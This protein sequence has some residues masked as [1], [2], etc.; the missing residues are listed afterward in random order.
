MRFIKLSIDGYGR[1]TDREIELA[2]GLQVVAGPNEQGKS[3]LRYFIADMLY[4][5]KRSAA[6]RLYE[7]SNELRAPWGNHR[8]YGGRLTYELD[9][10][11]VFEVQRRFDRNKE[12]THIFDRT[13]ACDITDQFPVA[14][15]RESTFAEAH[16][17]I[18][19][20]V[21]VGTATISHVSLADLGDQEALTRIRE[22]LLSLTDSAGE[23]NSAEDAIKML[24]E[25]VT[26]IGQPN[27]RTKPLPQARARLTDLQME[28][29]QVHEARRAIVEIEDERLGVLDEIDELRTRRAALESELAAREHFDQAQLLERAQGLEKRIDAVTKECFALRVLRDFPLARVPEVQ[30][31]VTLA[32]TARRQINRTKSELGVFEKQMDEQVGRLEREGQPIM[33]EC[34]PEW[35][36]ALADAD[37]RIQRSLGRLGELE[38]AR[39]E[40]EIRFMG[41][42]QEL[43]RLPDY[44]RL[45]SDPV[46]WLTQLAAN[47]DTVRRARDEERSTLAHL[48]DTAEQRRQSIAEASALF[49]GQEEVAERIHAYETERS[50]RDRSL[51][52]LAEEAASESAHAE[53]LAARLP[54]FTIFAA[55]SFVGTIVLLVIALA[56]G[57]RGLFL[58]TGLVAAMF[59]FVSGS[60]IVTRR[61]ASRAADNSQLL[62]EEREALQR[63]QP[64]QPIDVGGLLERSGCETTRELEAL[65]DRYAEAT[66][67]LIALDTRI[68]EQQTRVDDAAQQVDEMFA[69]LRTTFDGMGQTLADEDGVQTT[70]MRSIARYQEFRDSKRRGMEN[71][72]ALRRYETECAELNAALEAIRAEELERSLEVRA[73]LRDNH[74]ED[75]SN[76]DGALQALRAYRIRSAQHRQKQGMVD[77]SAG[78][79]KVLRRRIESEETDLASHEVALGTLLEGAGCETVEEFREKSEQAERYQVRWKERAALEDQLKALLGDKDV[80]SLRLSVR[81]TGGSRGQSDGRAVEELRGALQEVLDSLETKRTI[82]HDLHLK[83]AECSAGMRSMNEVDE[84]RESVE[85]RIREL[86]LELQ[87]TSYAISVIEE[88]TRERHTR[89]APKLADLASGYL[90]EIT[91]GV[92]DELLVDRDLQISIRIPQTKAMNADPERQLSKG[93]VDQIYLALRLAMVR[94]MSDQSET[95][96]MVLDDPFANYDD[97]RLRSAMR[98]I[99]K[100]GQTSQIILFTCRD[101]VVEAAR[102]VGAPIIQL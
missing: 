54:G 57:N 66:K 63:S 49:D 48:R 70:A 6:K 15:N 56:T 7:D 82:E 43:A 73:F 64:G 31:A 19:K 22:K 91:D 11:G 4:G 42:Q 65:Y 9:S 90:K 17:K 59:L 27:A 67:E 16:L 1:F 14:R 84:E 34:D 30:R 37:T 47:F 92:Y 96:P 78:Q 77:V 46:E 12:S 5:Q 3:T 40:A 61:G 20:S 35:E 93:T 75:E 87:A 88:V 69:E 13:N 39:S 18:T 60:V 97:H 86:E 83:L 76:Y 21:F 25:R 45:A 32:D 23:K 52:S 33:K 38:D 94:S 53:D 71:K 95:I 80:V 100:V 85:Q 102:A 58:P 41:A 2:P 89:I 72:E 36:T 62:E 51:E 68:E 101:D 28:Y 98:L 50:L 8:H 55:V 29:Q 79:I 74:F 26:S 44:T 81:Q 99:A 24:G 10:G